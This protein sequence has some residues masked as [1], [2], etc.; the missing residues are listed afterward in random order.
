MICLP[1]S[2][3]AA[4]TPAAIFAEILR[5]LGKAGYSCFLSRSSLVTNSANVSAAVASPAIQCSKNVYMMARQKIWYQVEDTVIV[6]KHWK[7]LWEKKEY[8]LHTSFQKHLSINPDG[9]WNDATMCYAWEYVTV[10]SLRDK[11]VQNRIE[12]NQQVKH[13][14]VHI[15]NDEWCPY[16]ANINSPGTILVMPIREVHIQCNDLIGMFHNWP[17]IFQHPEFA[18]YNF[19]ATCGMNSKDIHGRSKVLFNHF[20]FLDTNN[21]SCK[22]IRGVP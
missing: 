4:A 17:V 13:T 10:V 9:S 21:S 16:Q 18:S 8:G 12:L 15:H 14:E 6:Y 3:A 5:M 2:Y 7:L 1:R 20:S 11:Q 22:W 19:A